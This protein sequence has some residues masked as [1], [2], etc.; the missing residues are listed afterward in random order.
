MVVPDFLP[1]GGTAPDIADA[2]Y[3]PHPRQ[4]LDFWRATGSP[5]SAPVVV[6]IHGGGFVTGDKAEVRRYPIVRN[7]VDH[8]VA[9]AAVNYRYTVDGIHLPDP[10]RDAGRAVQFLRSMSREWGVDPARVAAYGV[11]AG[12][13]ASLWLAFHPDLAD[14]ASTDPVA[15]Q[16][17]RLVAAG[18][19]DGQATYDPADIST[20]PGVNAGAADTVPAWLIRQAF[21]V[22]DTHSSAAHALFREASP[23]HHLTR[24]DPP[25]FLFATGAQGAV[26]PQAATSGQA[27]A[28]TLG[29]MVGM[30]HNAAELPILHDPA[31]SR[32]LERELL[33][34]GTECRMRTPDSYR[35]AQFAPP[36]CAAW[37]EMVT[38]FRQRFG[39]PPAPPRAGEYAR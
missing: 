7:C 32:A 9:F 1:G 26:M 4:R 37:V 25:V 39:M 14:R 30:L 23:I 22:D 19:I 38:F 11:S 8:G 28:F 2:A 21:G 35:A 12:G 29:S 6:F 16:S 20:L 18:A 36:R 17:S 31:H 15:R 3:G 34:L 10:L 27:A 24:D 13:T 33:R 5:G